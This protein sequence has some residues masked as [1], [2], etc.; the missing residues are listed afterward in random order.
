[1]RIAQ[2]IHQFLPHH[3]GGTE[4]YTYNIC[5][6]LGKTQEVFIFCRED[7]LNKIPYKKEETY[8]GLSVC[9]IY[10]NGP[11][12]FE[13]TY[14]N[15]AIERY[16]S[17][18]LSKVKPDLV[19]FQHLERLS[20]S[21]I[22]I[23]KDKKIPSVVTLH[24]YWFICPGIRL[25]SSF[26]CACLEPFCEEKCG[27]C[28]N[29]LP[30]IIK[31]QIERHFINN[32]LFFKLGFLKDGKRDGF[33]IYNFLIKRILKSERPNFSEIK[34]RL[35]F[36]KNALSLASVIIAPSRFLRNRFIAYGIHQDKIIQSNYG[37]RRMENHPKNNKENEVIFGFIGAIAK[38]KGLHILVRAFKKIKDK[39]CKLKIF[40]QLHYNEY[41]SSINKLMK[42]DPR[43]IYY[44]HFDHGQ[45]EQIFSQIDVLIVPSIWQE[46]SP[47]VIHEAM[48]AKTP[49][50]AS[51]MGG[52]PELV[53]HR[54]NGLLFDIG[55]IESLVRG[56]RMFIDNPDLAAEFKK[57]CMEPKDIGENAKELRRIYE[58]VV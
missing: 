46:N 20:A 57:K 29:S 18:F 24:D 38:H 56:M 14:K 1:M 4:I 49:V 12:S 32:S 44:G 21:L 11:Y 48:S 54:S 34:N 16:F 51:N 58:S 47:L 35:N 2:V 25:I 5:K 17:E 40:G 13:S 43:I 7:A 15:P 50:I 9:R 23:A 26:G 41:F 33:K 53:T 37:I 6:E 19:H 3:H 52:M 36:M 55:D 39:N 45:T 31:Y 28:E 22:Q 8:D 42:Q 27:D 30:E 10:D